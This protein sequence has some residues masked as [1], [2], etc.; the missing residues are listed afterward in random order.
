MLQIADDGLARGRAPPDT[1]GVGLARRRRSSRVLLVFAVQARAQPEEAPILSPGSNALIVVD[2]SGSALP[3]SEGISRVLLA[4]TRDPRRHLGL[5]VFSDTAYEALPPSTPVEGLKG[6]LELFRT[7]KAWE[8]PWAPSFASGTVISSGLVLA[9]KLLRRDRDRAS[10]RRP[11]QRPRRRRSDLQK[12][13][14]VVAEYQRERIDLRV[15][16]VSPGAAPATDAVSRLPNA[17]FVEDAA[18]QIVD[19]TRSGGADSLPIVL[20]ALVCLV[21][22]ARGGKRA[23][24]PSADLEAQA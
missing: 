18:S 17:A 15:I 23:C 11:G 13:S 20:A 6:W 16:K 1:P 22:A 8:Y 14:T 4:L 10:A 19:P 12:L 21:G 24:A 9:R 7:G 5:V 2:L 3:S